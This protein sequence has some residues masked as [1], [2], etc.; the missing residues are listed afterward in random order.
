MAKG[1][2]P[3]VPGRSCADCAMCCM[4]L[5]IVAL[6]KP[7]SVWCE[8]CVAKKSC[9]IYDTRPDECRDFYCGY[10]TLAELGEEWKPSKSKI[11]L[12]SDLNGSRVT[13]H[14]DPKRPD[15]W[16]QEPYYST[17]KKWSKAAVPHGGMV[18][19]CVGARMYVIFPDRDVDL[20][21]V[22]PEDRIVTNEQRT[23]QGIRLEARVER[24]AAAK[25]SE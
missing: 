13:A 5:R 12:A 9:G 3:I 17:L 2:D 1:K 21:L 8:H 10:L 15:A 4:V 18:M 14:V 19:A 23:P 16:K 20:G 24:K 6:D 22:G 11:V 25:G 7:K